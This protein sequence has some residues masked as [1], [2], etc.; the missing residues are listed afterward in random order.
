MIFYFA[1]LEGEIQRLP[2]PFSANAESRCRPSSRKVS[3]KSVRE[4]SATL[5]FKVSRLRVMASRSRSRAEGPHWF[6]WFSYMKN[7]K[8]KKA[9]IMWIKTFRVS[10]GV[11]RPPR[12]WSNVSKTFRTKFEKSFQKFVGL[13]LLSGFRKR[14]GVTSSPSHFCFARAPAAFWVE[15][16]CT[17]EQ[18]AGA[19]ARDARANGKKNGS[20]CVVGWVGG[21]KREAKKN[22]PKSNDC[23]LFCK[24][25]LTFGA[26]WFWRRDF[27]TEPFLSFRHEIN[28]RCPVMRLRAQ[29]LKLQARET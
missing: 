5:N 23:G 22:L 8:T 21:L 20:F 9:G 16:F 6:C 11:L 26:Y 29:S 2:F 28:L 18:A 15:V 17:A 13:N 25:I 27:S 4:L 3:E 10:C 14:K 7:N 12:Q 1:S 19:R 24:M